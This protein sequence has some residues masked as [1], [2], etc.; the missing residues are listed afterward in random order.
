MN[1]SDADVD[2]KFDSPYRAKKLSLVDCVAGDAAR[3]CSGA[4]SGGT[5]CIVPSPVGGE[6]FTAVARSVSP[7]LT[8]EDKS[9]N[10]FE[11]EYEMLDRPRA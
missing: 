10:E 3:T 1:G 4:S 11:L 7:R 9:L 2:G 5:N 8:G 6:G